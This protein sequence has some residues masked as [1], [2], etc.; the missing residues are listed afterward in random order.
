MKAH[1]KL[2]IDLMQVGWSPELPQLLWAVPNNCLYSGR[3]P[4]FPLSG[5][6]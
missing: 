6:A 4:E 5:R 2:P 3:D 1:G